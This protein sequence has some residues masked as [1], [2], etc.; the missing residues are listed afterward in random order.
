MAIP[1][2]LHLPDEK[3]RAAFRNLP[4]LEGE[5]GNGAAVI[6]GARAARLTG[7]AYL[8]VIAPPEWFARLADPDA[9]DPAIIAFRDADKTI[10][11]SVPGSLPSWLCRIA[12]R[13]PA[14]LNWREPAA[15]TKP[16]RGEVCIGIVD[17]GIAIAHERLRCDTLE[18]RVEAYW[19]QNTLLTDREEIEAIKAFSESDL[20]GRAL[21]KTLTRK[22]IDAALAWADPHMD[23]DAIYRRLGLIDYRKAGPQFAAHRIAHGMHVADLAAGYA[24]SSAEASS[25]PVIAVQI[26]NPVIAR[27]I[28]DR[29]L[30]FHIWLG[31][32]FIVDQADRIWGENKMPLVIN[33]SLGKI[34]GPHDAT[35]L[36]ESAI[37]S[38]VKNREGMVH[39]VLPAGNHHLSQCHACIDLGE[40]TEKQV[41]WIVQPDDRTCST[42]EAWLPAGMA[43][44]DVM[45]ELTTPAGAKFTLAGEVADP[46]EIRYL[47]KTAG[48]I[49]RIAN[50]ERRAMIRI[51]IGPT[52]PDPLEEGDFSIAPSGRWT[53]KFEAAAPSCKGRVLLWS[54]RD[55]TLHGYPQAGRQ[56]YFEHRNHRMIAEAKIGSASRVTTL[57]EDDSHPEQAGLKSPVQRARLANAIATG[58]ET[59]VAGGNIAQTGEVAPY[60]AGG[61]VGTAG[62]PV[63]A[64][65][66][67]DVLMRSDDSRVHLGILAAGS[68][69]GSTVSLSGTSVAAPQLTRWVADL[70]ARDGATPAADLRKRME[71]AATEPPNSAG[72]EKRMGYG[73]LPGI[74]TR[75]QFIPERFE[76]D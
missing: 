1:F 36:L 49:S 46:V 25:R 44:E 52:V 53:L 16:R 19:D 8:A 4:P 55:D 23:E 2:L 62:E 57:V 42:V 76:R 47:G 24:P 12:R 18:S 43:A 37:D 64:R 17:D 29:R 74:E 9:R 32:L 75:D 69:S 6:G 5:E 61:P 7:G 50:G 68:H 21:G 40:G 48:K 45:C 41:D 72:C 3:V 56:S 65:R 30:D 14:A 35:G 63:F 31:I 51:D 11:L 10:R 39:V 58:E 20:Q 67:P 59:L 60:S 66:K 38:L 22:E 13:L 71:E 33:A 54:Q 73:N 15:S 27:P 28:D 70:L 34:A 26:A